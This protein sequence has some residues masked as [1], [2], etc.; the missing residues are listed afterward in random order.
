MVRWCEG[1]WLLSVDDAWRYSQC[2]QSFL[3][4]IDAARGI[5]ST[6][7]PTEQPLRRLMGGVLSA[8]RARLVRDLSERS[9]TVETIPSPIRAGVGPDQL[10]G[11]RITSHEATHRALKNRVDAIIHPA[12]AERD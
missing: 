2:P 3:N 10:L 7:P 6:P 9:S 12:F 4:T 11:E 8:H 5:A 1:T